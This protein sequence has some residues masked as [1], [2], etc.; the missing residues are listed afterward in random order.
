MVCTRYV[1]GIYRV[2]IGYVFKKAGQMV[3]NRPFD[4][5]PAKRSPE[6]CLEAKAQTLFWVAD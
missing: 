5:K 4:A 3:S 2:G 6:G 1:V